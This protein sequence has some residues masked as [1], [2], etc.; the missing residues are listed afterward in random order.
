MT[1]TQY[2]PLAPDALIA[3]L[4][5]ALT[6]NRVPG[7]FGFRF[8]VVTLGQNGAPLTPPTE[9]GLTRAISLLRMFHTGKFYAWYHHGAF[10]Q[11]MPDT[12]AEFEA[13]LDALAQ[14]Q[15]VYHHHVG[16]IDILQAVPTNE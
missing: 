5:Q 2:N 13:D 11:P 1:A 16:C 15:P 4:D 6:L 3:S 9:I 7:F 14:A 12:A 10:T 8:F